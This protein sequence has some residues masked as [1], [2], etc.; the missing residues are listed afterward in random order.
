M[1]FP[2][3]HN[4]FVR[5]KQAQ[6]EVTIGVVRMKGAEVGDSTELEDE[7]IFQK[8]SK[9]SMDGE[10]FLSVPIGK[11]LV[12]NMIPTKG[13]IFIEL[14]ATEDVTKS[15]II[16]PE[17]SRERACTG[18][19]ATTW[20]GCTDFV[21]GNRVMLM[22]G[23]GVPVIFNEKELLLIEEGMIVAIE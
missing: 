18:K 11:I 21:V 12:K 20:N 1:I 14:D 5:Q 15:G 22:K 2:P 4:V 23:V 13:R 19:I 9:F 17:L 7:I 3:D 8:T 16:I 6:T 10:E